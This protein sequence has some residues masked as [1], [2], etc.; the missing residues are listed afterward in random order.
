MDGL[1]GRTARAG[2]PRDLNDITSQRA[3][4]F[5]VGNALPARSAGIVGTGTAWQRRWAENKGCAQPP[6]NTIPCLGV[7]RHH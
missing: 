6:E 2:S 5:R 1:R 3:K 4:V 7:G